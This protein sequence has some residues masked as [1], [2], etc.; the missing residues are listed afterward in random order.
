MPKRTLPIALALATAFTLIAHDASAQMGGGMGMGGP[1][2]GAGKGPPQDKRERASPSAP[3]AAASTLERTR[4]EL[5]AFYDALRPTFVQQPAFERFRKTLLAFA[6]DVDRAADGSVR[7]QGPAPKQLAAISD[8]MNARA[9]AVDDIVAAAS[10]LYPL[11]DERQKAL[12]DR[13]MVTLLAEVASGRAAPGGPPGAEGPGPPAGR[14]SRP[15][16]G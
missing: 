3:I 12:A 9:T 2:G 7:V 1:G 10:A 11:L 5:N 6:S 4:D 14:P 8:Q 15:P 13:Q 16:S